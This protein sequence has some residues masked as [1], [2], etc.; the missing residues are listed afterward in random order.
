MTDVAMT[1]VA[2]AQ[3]LAGSGVLDWINGLFDG[4]GITASK[5][6]TLASVCVVL[7]V[8]YRG[9]WSF[10]SIVLGVF[11]GGLLYWGG[12]NTGTVSD[13]VDKD[14]KAISQVSVVRPV[15]GVSPDA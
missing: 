9:R 6:I 10:P 14:M 11:L 13:K 5:A 15:T 12:H 2:G 3:A 1:L 8:A 4:L 7:F